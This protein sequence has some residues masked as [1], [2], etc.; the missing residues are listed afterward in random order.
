[1][2]QIENV[3]IIGWEHAMRG[4]RNPKN[5]WS[6]SDSSFDTVKLGE[7]DIKLAKQ[8]RDGGSVHAKYR[9]M[10]AVY[11]DITAPLYF[12]KEADTYKVG[13]VANSCSTMHKIADKRFE[14]DDFSHE[15]LDDDWKDR[16]NLVRCDYEYGNTPIDILCIIVDA[17]NQYRNL[18]L[19]RK[20]KKYWWQMIQLLPTSY[21]QKRTVMLN[22]EVLA[23]IYR[24]RKDH[25]LDEWR[26]FCKWIESLPYSELITGERI[27]EI[28]TS[29]G[30]LVKQNGGY[31]PCAIEKTEDTK[32]ICKDFREAPEGTVCH[33]G[34]YKK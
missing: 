31:C 21:N 10:I 20:D 8:L 32:C 14:L 5:S 28:D 17:L 25:K 23:N 27:T 9:R 15:H 19:E 34:R 18:Y 1:M 29:I 30:E 22:Y 16:E 7:N 26:E 33:C 13:T 11:A 12:W 2:I 6:K 24:W 4:M 3:E